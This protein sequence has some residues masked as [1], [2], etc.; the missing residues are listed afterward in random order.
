[1]KVLV[2]GSKGQL[3]RCIHDQLENKNFEVIYTSRNQIDVG[4][5]EITRTQILDIAPDTIINASAYT[6]VDR[7][8][9]ENKIANLINSVALG[10]LAKISLELD[11]W[12]IHLSTDYVFDG[13]SSIAYQEEDL[14]NPQ[15][16]YGETKLNGEIAIQS[17]GCKYII[18]RS[19]WIFSEYGNNFLKTMLHLANINDELSVV[20]DQIGCPTYAQDIAKTIVLILPR[21]NSNKM[22]NGV[23][24]YCGDQILSWHGFAKAIFEE[25]KILGFKTPK[26]VNKIETLALQQTAS[27]PSYSVLDCAKI[28]KNFGITTSNCRL[29]IQSTLKKLSRIS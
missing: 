8:E 5:L 24:H 3:G 12:L 7:A 4:N 28:D 20:S 25:A 29:G 13:A 19:A 26:F 23:Y 16:V 1:M 18:L 21:L 17:S 22:L 10:N 14:T 11:C 6:A 15:S 27:R 9:K 2:L